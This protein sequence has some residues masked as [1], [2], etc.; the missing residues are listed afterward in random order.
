MEPIF[1]SII[2]IA[3]SD[4]YLKSHYSK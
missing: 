4:Y 1:N 2:L 3:K